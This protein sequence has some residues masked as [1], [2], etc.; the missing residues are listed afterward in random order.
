MQ[1]LSYINMKAGLKYLLKEITFKVFS[2]RIL[3][4][5]SHAKQLLSLI[6]GKAKQ[7]KNLKA[8][9]QSKQINKQT[10]HQKIQRPISLEKQVLQ[11]HQVLLTHNFPIMLVN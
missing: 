3:L 2:E 6:R 5:W 8:H 11:E 9:K 7:N 4:G 10:K 1:P